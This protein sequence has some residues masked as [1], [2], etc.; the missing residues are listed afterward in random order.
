MQSF[1]SLDPSMAV[2][3][4]TI[5]SF[6]VL[7]LSCRSAKAQLGRLVLGAI[8]GFFTVAGVFIMIKCGGLSFDFAMTGG[9]AWF[10]AVTL[11]CCA[12][13]GAIFTGVFG[14]LLTRFL[15]RPLCFAL[16]YL[17]LIPIMVGAYLNYTKAVDAEVRIPENKTITAISLPDGT[18]FPLEFELTVSRAS[19]KLCSQVE[20]VAA[21]HK[22]VETLYTKQAVQEG[23]VNLSFDAAIIDGNHYF[24][25]SYKPGRL[26][27]M[28]G[29]ILFFTSLL[30]TLIFRN[31]PSNPNKN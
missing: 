21:R 22:R 27:L 10:P 7:L 17:S 4:L 26:W 29:N 31:S 16:A 14:Y 2:I 12:L 18:S 1:P 30:L 28:I 3:L 11:A 24:Q 6:I 19:Q 13:V 20:I 15:N 25:F 8:G 5:F 23:N 9:T